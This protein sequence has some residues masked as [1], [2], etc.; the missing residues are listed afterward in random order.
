MLPWD[1]EEKLS[2]RQAETLLPMESCLKQE[3][4]VNSATGEDKNKT[5]DAGTHGPSG[6]LRVRFK[7]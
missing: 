1:R 2:F 7:F 3:P 4:T 6:R 5:T